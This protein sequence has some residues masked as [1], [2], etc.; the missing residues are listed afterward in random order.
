MLDSSNAL[1]HQSPEHTLC[2]SNL[3]DRM[4]NRLLVSSSSASGQGGRKISPSA[5]QTIQP[6]FSGLQFG[7][8]RR[9]SSELR[10]AFTSSWIEEQSLDPGD[11]LSLLAIRRQLRSFKVAHAN[12]A[13]ASPS[14]LA[15]AWGRTGSACKFCAAIYRSN[16]Q[17]PILLWLGGAMTVLRK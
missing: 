4:S 17:Q 2:M 3:Q 9:G 14:F 16:I 5:L 11:P 10:P 12:C 13:D 15:R 8:Y 7:Q 1:R 6:P